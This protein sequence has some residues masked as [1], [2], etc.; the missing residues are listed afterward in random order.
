MDYGPHCVVFLPHAQPN[1]CILGND[2]CKALDQ[3]GSEA[4]ALAAK[5]TAGAVWVRRECSSPAIQMF[6]SNDVQQSGWVLLLLQNELCFAGGFLGGLHPP[7][8]AKAAAA[9]SLQV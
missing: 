9:Q 4:A 1:H 2:P 3:P 7:C 6:H 5:G 8:Y